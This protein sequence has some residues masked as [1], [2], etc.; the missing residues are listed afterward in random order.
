M[1]LDVI[2]VYAPDSNSATAGPSRD[3]RHRV[4]RR[5]HRGRPMA[6]PIDSD[7]Q[8]R[9]LASFGRP[10]ISQT[11]PPRDG[12]PPFAGAHGYAARRAIRIGQTTAPLGISW[13]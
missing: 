10:G 11:R 7:E 4:R 5:G 9:D 6:I 2:G 13:H 1:L 8:N 12:L 3:K